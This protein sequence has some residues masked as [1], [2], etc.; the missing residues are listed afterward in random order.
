MVLYPVSYRE[1]IGGIFWIC[2]FF[3][4]WAGFSRTD[5]SLGAHCTKCPKKGKYHIY[6]YKIV[7][8]QTAGLTT[9]GMSLVFFTQILSLQLDDHIQNWN[10]N[11]AFVSWSSKLIQEKS[12]HTEIRF[13]P[14]FFQSSW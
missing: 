9:T 11:P 4:I 3:V 2:V 5:V 8:K 7:V 13:F 10:Q 14:G 12:I 6:D 1:K